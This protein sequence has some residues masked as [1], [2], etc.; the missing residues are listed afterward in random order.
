MPRLLAALATATLV[1]APL[2]AR[3]TDLAVWWEQGFNPEEDAAVRET[4]TAFEQKTGK[5][6]ELV[7]YPVDELPGKLV[8]AL[9]SASRPT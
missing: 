1:I 5:Q 8:T 6:V 4:I 7:F 3:A 9:A 2:G